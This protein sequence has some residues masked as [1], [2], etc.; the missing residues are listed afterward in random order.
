MNLFVGILAALTLM[1]ASTHYI[2]GMATLVNDE[3]VFTNGKLIAVYVASFLVV[4]GLMIRN[5]LTGYSRRQIQLKRQALLVMYGFV[6]TALLA[7]V[8]NLIIPA[9][10]ED[11]AST[12]VG[13]LATVILV[14]SISYAIVKHGLFN[15]RLF[16]A[17]AVAYVGSITILAAVYG[18]LVFSAANLLFGLHV[19]IQTEIFL[20]LATGFAGLVFQ[21]PIRMFNKATNRLFYR[22]GY[23]AQ[24]LFDKLNRLLVSSMNLGY[25]LKNSSNIL[26]THLKAETVNF[27][28]ITTS[29]ENYRMMG[30]EGKK[31]PAVDFGKLH[32]LLKHIKDGVVVGDAL[33]ERHESLRNFM[34]KANIAV[35]VRLSSGGRKSA[36][37][38]GYIFLGAK[39]SGGLY[40]GQDKKVLDTVSNM[41]IIA[42]QN[43][44]HYEEIQ[45]FN[46]TLQQRVDEATRQ[47]KRTNAK[48][49][50]LDETKDDFISMASHQLRTPLTSVKG[51]ISMVLDG[52]AGKVT[53]TQRKM[54]TQAFISSQ[55]MVY[56]IADLLNVSRLKTGKFVIEP[57]PTN[58]SKLVT[59]EVGQLI[60]TA[61]SR[62]IKLSY[63]RP[64]HLPLLNLDETKTRQVIMNFVDNA[65]YYTPGG[66]HIK[67]SLVEK[68]SAVELR[69]KD[70]G[71]GVPASEQHHL[72]TKFYRARNAQKA[73][74]D[75]TGLGLFMAKKVIAAQG[76]A[77]IFE[78]KEGKGSTFGFTFSKSKLAVAE[79][80]PEKPAVA[81]TATL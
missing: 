60:E 78:S 79:P 34:V 57:T 56:L 11:W 55:R 10:F 69:V 37:D 46:V 67:V 29:G 73:R 19:P 22:D 75:G 30:S 61:A 13:P 72:F 38:E 32:S 53:P 41:L 36:Q 71:I 9:I 17:R 24:E 40:T 2:A 63:D 59:E 27:A 23:D 43:A 49:E 47:L 14:G 26:A 21:R 76:G 39:R 12:R 35:I 16:A 25:M 70:D 31:F 15:V 45:R 58:L 44:L 4:I 52:D 3:L 74:P 64:A 42:I 62:N 48:L 28:L 20:S 1:L 65:I 50:A 66:G 81:A 33:D 7:L 51:Y 77:L 68:P 54:L 18:I 6:L 80:T 5:L 8:S